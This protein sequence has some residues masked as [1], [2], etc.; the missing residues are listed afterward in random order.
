MEEHKAFPYHRLRI[1]N[2]RL[3][4]GIALPTVCPYSQ[5]DLL[6]EAV[7]LECL[8]NTQDSLE[9]GSALEGLLSQQ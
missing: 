5:V 9:D 1:I 8:C 2:V 3:V 4:N 7:R 6:L